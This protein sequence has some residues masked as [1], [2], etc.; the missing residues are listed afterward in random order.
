MI[1]LSDNDINYSAPYK[2]RAIGG[3]RIF[4]STDYGVRYMVGFDRDDDTMKIT[5]YQFV[6]ANANNKPSP[7]DHKVRETIIAIVEDFF[8]KNN[9][10]MLYIC[11]T[12]DNKQSMR[13]RL[14]E[15]WF[16]HYDNKHNFTFLSSSV[17]DEDGIINY[18]TLISRNDNPNL[19]KA[20]KEFGDTV[21]LLNSKPTDK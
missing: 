18:A 14:F 7:R 4:F 2:V 1:I 21:E 3:G 8:E 13:S 5:T 10:V 12:G 19:S 20:I 17:K 16:N 15:Y 6:I 9:E 11:E